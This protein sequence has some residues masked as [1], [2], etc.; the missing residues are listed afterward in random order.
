MART[1]ITYK[2]R[3]SNYVIPRFCC[4]PWT[5]SVLVPPRFVPASLPFRFL[6]Y[7]S[8]VLVLVFPRKFHSAFTLHREINRRR[9]CAGT[10]AGVIRRASH[11]SHS[12]KSH[13]GIRSDVMHK[14]REKGEKNMCY[15]FFFYVHHRFFTL[16]A[17]EIEIS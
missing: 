7:Y 10:F 6:W 13:R 12:E 8:R 3:N 14:R 2:E 1:V 9:L 4:S 5:R 16:T 11:H 15:F 17:V